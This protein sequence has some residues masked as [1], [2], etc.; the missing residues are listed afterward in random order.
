MQVDVNNQVSTSSGLTKTKLS[1]FECVSC[2]GAKYDKPPSLSTG[3]ASA[4]RL[5]GFSGSVGTS[6][7]GRLGSTRSHN[8]DVVRLDPNSRRFE[9]HSL[10]FTKGCSPVRLVCT[11][12]RAVELSMADSDCPLRSVSAIQTTLQWVVMLKILHSGR[13]EAIHLVSSPSGSALGF[14][15]T[16]H[17]TVRR[18]DGYAAQPFRV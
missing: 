2:W 5:K 4:A 8:H 7:L 9:T 18:C 16:S 10:Q 15:S 3:C 11:R 12:R 1:L 13:I 17:S 14:C 6:T